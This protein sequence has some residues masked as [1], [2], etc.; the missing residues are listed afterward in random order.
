MFLSE[1]LSV[2]FCVPFRVIVYWKFIIS[3]F[4]LVFSFFNWFFIDICIISKKE[5]D[6]CHNIKLCTHIHFFLRID[7][8]KCLPIW[9]KTKT[10]KYKTTTMTATISSATTKKNYR[11]KKSINCI[12]DLRNKIKPA[13]K[14]IESWLEKKGKEKKT[15]NNEKQEWINEIGKTINN[16]APSLCI[17]WK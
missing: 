3:H 2:S 14:G 4:I 16:H 1:F 15:N 8:S 9:C 6:E 12:Y 17:V 7:F 5:I 11:K 10:K 13:R